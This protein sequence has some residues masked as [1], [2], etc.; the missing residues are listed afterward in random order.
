MRD[1]WL[2]HSPRGPFPS[3]SLAYNISGPR[4]A[5]SRQGTDHRPSPRRERDTHPLPPPAWMAGRCTSVH[6]DASHV[7][8]LY[9]FGITSTLERLELDV[10]SA[11]KFDT[12]PLLSRRKSQASPRAHRHQRRHGPAGHMRAPAGGPSVVVIVD[13]ART[14]R[15]RGLRSRRR[16]RRLRRRGVRSQSPWG[17]SAVDRRP[18]PARPL[19]DHALGAPVGPLGH[20]DDPALGQ[21]ALRRRQ[22][23]DAGREEMR[24]AVPANWPSWRRSACAKRRAGRVSWAG[25]RPSGRAAGRLGVR[26]AWAHRAV[27][28]AFGWCAVG[29]SVSPGRSAPVGQRR[30]GLGGRAQPDPLLQNQPFDPP[31]APPVLQFRKV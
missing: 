12:S 1:F 25:G 24:R 11:L 4:S 8:V 10:D 13:I 18:F 31:P 17:R 3:T 7:C 15:R 30:S 16:C 27:G 20:L 21:R 14:R 9:E 22:G 5:S 23:R 26:A 2:L 28:R 19:G 6:D 29:R